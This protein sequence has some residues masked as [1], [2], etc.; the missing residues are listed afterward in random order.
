M[1]LQMLDVDD[2]IRPLD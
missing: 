2:L 1:F